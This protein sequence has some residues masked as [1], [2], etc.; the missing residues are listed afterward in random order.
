MAIFSGDCGTKEMVPRR[1]T[2]SRQVSILRCKLRASPSITAI[3]ETAQS[4]QA[5]SIQ[6]GDDAS[7]VRRP[8]YARTVYSEI[9]RDGSQ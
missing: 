5:L 4:L 1:L 3:D 9:D 7:L 8:R 6:R 2:S